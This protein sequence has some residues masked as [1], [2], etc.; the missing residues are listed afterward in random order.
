MKAVVA[1]EVTKEQ[2][3]KVKAIKENQRIAIYS[4]FKLSTPRSKDSYSPR[5]EDLGIFSS[6]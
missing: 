6:A 1:Y 4:H 3:T 2:V 5:I